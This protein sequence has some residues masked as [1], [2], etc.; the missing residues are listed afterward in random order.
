MRVDVEDHIQ[1][2]CRDTAMPRDPRR[3]A[4]QDRNGESEAQQVKSESRTAVHIENRAKALPA[5]LVAVH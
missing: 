3:M 2:R 1:E 4:K 5:K